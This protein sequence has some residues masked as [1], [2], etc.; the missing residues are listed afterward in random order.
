MSKFPSVFCSD[1]FSL[2]KQFQ[3]LF[4]IQDKFKIILQINK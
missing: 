1:V 2:N 3:Y 4:S